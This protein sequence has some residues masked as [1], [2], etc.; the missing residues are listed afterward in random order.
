VK[1]IPIV[2][3]VVLG[4]AGMLT[5]QDPA[6]AGASKLDR[7]RSLHA[8]YVEARDKAQKEQEPLVAELG[9]LERGSEEAR[10][11]SAQLSKIRAT[12]A[13]PQKAFQDAFTASTWQRFDPDQDA[14]LLKD[15]LPVVARDLGTSPECAVEAC[16]LYL[17]HFGEERLA[18]QI[19]GS[20]LPNALLAAGRAGDA[21]KTLQTAVD[22]TSGA[23]KAR[24]L[25][26]LGDIRAAM[27]DVAGAAKLYAEAD[28][29]ADESTKRYVT[30][31]KELI[32]QPAPEI[33]SNQWIGGAATTLGALKGKVVLVDFWATWCGPCR[34]VMPGLNEL[35]KQRHADGLEVMGVT[36]FYDYGYMPANKDQMLTG[37]QSVRGLTEETFTQHVTDF[38]QHTGIEY[39]FVVATKAEFDAYKVSGIPTLAVV[40][41]DGN[42]ALITVG[43]GSEPLLKLAVE[44]LL[45]KTKK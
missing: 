29:V 16:N 6:E 27:G 17:Q 42:I 3:S 14:A 44:N 41:R 15:G 4:I 30:L 38:K 18:D 9:K 24:A 26:T 19:R 10:K 39:P 5:A 36:R 32:G 34:H 22:K 1:T 11:I 13:A 23:T 21:A 31:R 37:G 33:A 25:L 8:A 43:S 35:Y 2:A 40:G 28:A 45:A 20:Y 7:V 12:T